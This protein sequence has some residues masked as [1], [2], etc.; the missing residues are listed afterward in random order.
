MLIRKLRLGIFGVALVLVIAAPWAIQRRAEHRLQGQVQALRAKTGQLNP[1]LAENARLSN[2]VAQTKPTKALSPEQFAALLHLRG[3]VGQ[4]HQQV[5]QLKQVETDE[6][7]RQ[8]E[9]ADKQA[10]EA[11]EASKWKKLDIK[12][13]K[14]SWTHVGYTTPADAL[15]SALWAR[16][17]GDFQSLV[18]SLAPDFVQKAKKAWGDQFED[19]LKSM[20]PWDTDS[21]DDCNI[22][23]E[24]AVSDSQ[25]QLIYVLMERQKIGDAARNVATGSM[26]RVKRV[27]GEWKL[28]P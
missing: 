13:P 23:S 21:V 2:F 24:K 10:K 12:L 7:Q 28:E 6:R 27:G 8:A 17:E 18:A 11:E 1:L 5:S 3:E 20:L 14:A 26:I 9:A 22:V 25:V 16:R 19:K 4:L 15:Q